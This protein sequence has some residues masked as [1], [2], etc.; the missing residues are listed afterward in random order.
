[1]FVHH[2]TSFFYRFDGISGFSLAEAGDMLFSA[3]K[4]R[5]GQEMTLPFNFLTPVWYRLAIEVSRLTLTV[6]K[7]CDYFGY[8]GICSLEI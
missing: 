2:F 6:E 1:V 4:G 5:A 8:H 7:L 3:A